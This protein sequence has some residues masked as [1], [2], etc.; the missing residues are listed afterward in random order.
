M[1]LDK[2]CDFKQP[3]AR[4]CLAHSE[5]DHV[6]IFGGN[7]AKRRLL[8]EHRLSL[9]ASLEQF[10]SPRDVGQGDTT[11]IVK[12]IQQ[13][14]YDVV[15]SW[16]KF[17]SHASRAAIRKACAISSTRVVEVESLSEIS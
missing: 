16:T 13:G 17:N 7:P 4:I 9:Y 1:P 15:Y 8:V 14:R 5:T 12:R 11:S 10:G 6:A 3:A 2:S